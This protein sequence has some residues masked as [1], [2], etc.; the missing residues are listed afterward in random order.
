MIK[1]IV[2][3]ENNILAT[4]TIRK[5]LTSSLIEYGFEVT[6]LTTGSEEDMT[7]AKKPGIKV[8]DIGSSGEDLN[9]IYRYVKQ[10]HSALKKIEPDLC[11]T[12]TIRPN[13]WGNFIAE[14]LGIPV[15]SNI[16]GIG[17][18]F[19]TD[20]L[21]YKILR[22]LLRFSLKNTRWI[23]FQNDDDRNL[24]IEKKYVSEDRSETIPGS[25]VDTDF[26]APSGFVAEK[27]AKQFSFLFIGRLIKDK[28]V[29]EFV[30]AAEKVKAEF[31]YVT[32]K[33]V[34]P[35]WDQASKE[36]QVP[37]EQIEEWVHKGI[38]EY[39]SSVTDVRPY[40]AEA[41][42]VVLPSYRE[43]LSNVLLEAGSMETI[44]IASNVTGCKEVIVDGETGFLCHSR[45]VD[46][47][48]AKMKDVINLPAEKRIQMGKSARKRIQTL[49]EKQSVIDA[50]FKAINKI[51]PSK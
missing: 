29:F 13:I 2:M 25:G 50:Y 5:K 36:N 40:I 51:E 45:D 10:L 49:F 19:E 16:T 14:R 4:N 15:I 26:F 33:V 42:C 18:F 41:D 27:K 21:Q 43:G 48:V 39:K 6:V 9:S 35:F 7:V 11:L 28:G 46:D 23:F 1:K 37:K 34:G 31:P 3:I 12:F 30:K 44:C 20:N 47:L 17:S 38:I 22:K 32:F 8:L 24:F